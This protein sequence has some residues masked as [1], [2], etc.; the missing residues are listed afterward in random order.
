MTR[1]ALENWRFDLRHLQ[2]LQPPSPLSAVEDGKKS[3]RTRQSS[4]VPLEKFL[5][6]QSERA[7]AEVAARSRI[8]A[9]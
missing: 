5:L 6:S 4:Q 2:P 9:R 1:N 3:K 8:A 7:E